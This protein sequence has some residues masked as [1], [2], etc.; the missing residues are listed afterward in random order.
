MTEKERELRPAGRHEWEQILGRLRV[1]GVLGSSGRTGKNGRSTKGAVS[2][3]AFKAIAARFAF[4]GDGDGTRIWPGDAVVAVD[5]ETTIDRVRTVRR[6][7]IQ[8]GL[9][10]LVRAR[11][12]ERGEEYRLTLPSDLL[13]LLEVL[14]P[15]QHKV[16]A[17]NMREARRGPVSKPAGSASLGGPVDYPE[18]EPGWSGGLPRDE[19]SGGPVDY[20]ET[21]ACTSTGPPEMSSGWSGGPPPG[22]SGG[23]AY[24]PRPTTPPTNHADNDLRA[25]VTV[26]RASPPLRKPDLAEVGWVDPPPAPAGPDACEH[27]VPPGRFRCPACNRG[28]AAVGALPRPT[29]G[30]DPPDR[31]ELATVLAFR[32]RT[33]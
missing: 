12:G 2:A 27:G 28:L 3:I 19:N 31:D 23:H 7:L 22:W 17:H 13:D 11:R 29:D 4:Y 8:W 32:P 20:P 14:T 30:P 9:L 1:S 5:L 15:A 10:E 18:R 26:S 21:D 24:Q 33:A 6:A 25:A 16:A